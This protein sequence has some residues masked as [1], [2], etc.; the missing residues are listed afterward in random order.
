MVIDTILPHPTT[1]K[2]VFCLVFRVLVQS[3]ATMSIKFVVKST[4]IRLS[5]RL[6]SLDDARSPSG[7][8][9]HPPLRTPARGD[10]GRPPSADARERILRRAPTARGGTTRRGETA[11]RDAREDD[12]ARRRRLSSDEPRVV[13]RDGRLGGV[14]PGDDGQ[15]IHALQRAARGDEAT[16]GGGGGAREVSRARG[17]GE[18]VIIYTTRGRHVVDT[19]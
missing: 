9:S 18:H 13:H 17:G 15:G 5:S 6:P 19:S 14:V 12:V 1:K 16:R 8:S 7:R 3:V 4:L 2:T 10:R 11:A